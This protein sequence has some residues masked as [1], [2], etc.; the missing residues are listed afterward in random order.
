MN[1]SREMHEIS[2]NDLD[3]SIYN[4]D[5]LFIDSNIQS[6][7]FVSTTAVN[8]LQT[9]LSTPNLHR[10]NRRISNLFV[11][12]FIIFIFLRIFFFLLSIIINNFKYE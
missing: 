3:Q 11:C 12:F 7:N 6:S 10:K 1:S 9:P 4:R 5:E 2:K 8:H